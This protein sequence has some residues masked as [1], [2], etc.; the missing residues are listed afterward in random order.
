MVV[1][2]EFVYLYAFIQKI[3]GETVV[4]ILFGTDGAPPR[5]DPVFIVIEY[6]IVLQ[7]Q[8]FTGNQAPAV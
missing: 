8:S 1:V 5:D 3:A 7:K 4:K 6:D 2:V